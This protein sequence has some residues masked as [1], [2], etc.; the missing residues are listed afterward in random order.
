MFNREEQAE[1]SLHYLSHMID[2]HSYFIEET[3]EAK[4]IKRKTSPSQVEQMATWQ[5]DTAENNPVNER[6]ELGDHS[7]PRSS[8]WQSW[9]MNPGETMSAHWGSRSSGS[10]LTHHLGP[11]CL[12]HVMFMTFISL[13]HVL[14]LCHSFKGCAL[15]PSLLFHSHSLK[16]GSGS[17]SRQ[18]VY[19][20]DSSPPHHTHT[21]S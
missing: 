14:G 1:T 20:W 12:C 7:W 4:E 19:S 3:T 16:T 10:Q 9:D 15:P 21:A 6:L 8:K 13:C 2:S 5:K 18:S 11:F 17:D